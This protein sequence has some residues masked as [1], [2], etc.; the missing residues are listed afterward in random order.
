MDLL[1]D[2]T[3]RALI[4]SVDGVLSSTFPTSRLRALYEAGDPY[5]DA[6]WRTGCGLGWQLLA[7]PEDLGGAGGTLVE[8]GLVF[9]TLGRHVASGPW[10]GTALAATILGELGDAELLAPIAAGDVRYGVGVP[11]SSPN[12]DGTVRLRVMDA[13]GANACITWNDAGIWVFA[14]PQSRAVQALDPADSVHDITWRAKPSASLTAP[15]ARAR[16]VGSALIAATAAGVASR[17]VD[18]AVSHAMTREQFGRPIGSFQAIK[19]RCADMALRREAAVSSSYYALAAITGDK[20]EAAAAAAAALLVA[21]D[22]AVDNAADCVQVYGAMGFT[23]EC[24]AHLYL[25]RAH[26]LRALVGVLRDPT[27]PK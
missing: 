7:V 9:E 12:E 3:L 22:A 10:F 18:L 11:T 5:D 27:E 25:K 8:L 15:P 1:L 14:M 6:L 24:D 4:S 23:W 20:P 26:R 2:E 17:C 21:T 16:L 13:A 19:H